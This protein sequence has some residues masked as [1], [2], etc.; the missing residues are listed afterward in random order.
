[1]ASIGDDKS[2]VLYDAMKKV[3]L[4]QFSTDH[5]ESTPVVSF[6]TSADD[7]WQL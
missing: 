2:I 6:S 5:C 4:T 3:K 1:M 7:D